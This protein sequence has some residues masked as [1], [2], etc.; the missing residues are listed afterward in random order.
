MKID[1]LYSHL[2]GLEYLCYHH[3][4]LWDEIQT[5]IGAVDATS[6]RTKISREKGRQGTLLYSPV[7]L[8]AAFKTQF[9]KQGWIEQRFSFY[10]TDDEVLLRQIMAVDRSEQRQRIRS[11]NKLP[12]ASYNQ[13]DFVKD[14]IA[15]EV[16]LGKYSFVAHDLFVKHLSFYVGDRIDLGIEI[17]PMKSLEEQMSSGVAYYERD[18]LNVVRQGRGVP[19]VPLILIGIAP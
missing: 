9:A 1:N 14:R 15:V 12:I 8:N 19:A 7:D 2:N 4:P 5:I 3:Q 16:Q 17:V 6:C 18:L 13:I 11:A 10:T